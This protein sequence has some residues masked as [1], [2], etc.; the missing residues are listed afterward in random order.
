[1]S[2]T[3]KFATSTE[4]KL[5]YTLA[6]GGY[7]ND[8]NSLLS[9][10]QFKFK[11]LSKAFCQSL[12]R[13]NKLKP[14]KTIRLELQ[15][16]IKNIKYN[17]Q[18]QIIKHDITNDKTLLEQG[19]Q[20][21]LCSMHLFKI[22]QPYLTLK[23]KA[24]YLAIQLC[25]MNDVDMLNDI[26]LLYHLFINLNY[27]TRNGKT[28]LHYACI[29][30]SYDIVN[31]LI[32]HNVDLTLQDYM[33]KDK[34]KLNKTALHYAVE[35]QCIDIIKCLSPNMDVNICDYNEKTSLVYAGPGPKGHQQ[36]FELLLQ[37]GAY[38]NI[39]YQNTTLLNECVKINDYQGTKYL[40]SL[41]ADP[42]IACAI[43]MTLYHKMCNQYYITPLTLIKTL[44]Y[45]LIEDCFYQ[46]KIINLLSQYMK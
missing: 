37:Y 18:Q 34:S 30:N 32:K 36:I 6:L 20:T 24:T 7:I 39:K 43:D 33:N 46:F 3:K 14:N 12:Q 11:L 41:G 2:F 8:L 38:I 35:Y 15:H 22:L 44:Q 25:K 9:Q 17:R 23:K 26:H 29:Y 21:Y 4:I 45:E 10:F 28:M 42:Y 40:L 19:E 5:L 16:H 1:M 13:A 31:Y 27:Q